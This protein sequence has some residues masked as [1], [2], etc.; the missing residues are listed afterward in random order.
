MTL[1]LNGI[2]VLAF[3]I[4]FLGDSTKQNGCFK[5]ALINAKQKLVTTKESGLEYRIDRI[6]IAAALQG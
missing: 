3:I 6:D 2:V 1:T 4:E 5:M